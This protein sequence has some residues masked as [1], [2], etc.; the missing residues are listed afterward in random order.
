[1]AF[2]ITCP[3]CRRRIADLTERCPACG[4][5]LGALAGLV[6]LADRHFNDAVR[7]ARG[8]R[9]NTAAEHLAVTLALNPADAEARQLLTKVR[10]HQDPKTLPDRLWR[11]ARTHLPYGERLP[12]AL[13]READLRRLLD[14][15]SKRLAAA[16]KT[17]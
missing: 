12:V 15:A 13:P 2:A 3:L 6:E 14:G 4:G 7:S 1:M 11:K 5:D 16:R 8:R 10:Y 9:W 17:G